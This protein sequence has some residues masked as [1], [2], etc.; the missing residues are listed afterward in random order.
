MDESEIKK[1]NKI[2][3]KLN[4]G[5]RRSKKEVNGTLERILIIEIIFCYIHQFKRQQ[6][7]QRT[8]KV[9]KP[10]RESKRYL[11]MAITNMVKATV[12]GTT[13]NVEKKC[14]RSLT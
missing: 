11:H 14:L 12:D 8:S 2:K 5:R 6:H 9:K 13:K 1:K 10:I 3:K 7:Q 4:D